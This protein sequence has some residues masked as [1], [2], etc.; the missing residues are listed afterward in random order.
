MRR[1]NNPHYITVAEGKNILTKTTLFFFLVFVWPVL[2]YA[3]V[4]S[5]K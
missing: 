4:M 2:V 5:I 1:N 3:L